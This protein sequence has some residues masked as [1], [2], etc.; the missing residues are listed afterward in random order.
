MFQG[1]EWEM[2]IVDDW[3]SPKI[4]SHFKQIKILN[5]SLRILLV[6]GRLKVWFLS[7]F[8]GIVFNKLSNA[9]SYGRLQDT[10]SEYL[11][12]L[13]L[14]ETHC[15]LNDDN[16]LAVNSRDDIASLK[17][18]LAKYIINGCKS[19]S[20]RFVEYWVPVQISNIQLEQYCAT[21]ISNSLSLCS[22]S[23]NDPVGALCNTLVTIRKVG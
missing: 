3:Q 21:L 13:T 8:T 9:L 1:V 2:I 7:S 17:E 5:S 4:S 11:N 18:R 20:F 22:P 6:S 14:L 19:E 16:H 12:L 10:S 15:I 23:K